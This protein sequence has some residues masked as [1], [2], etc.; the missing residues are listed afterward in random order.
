MGTILVSVDPE[1]ISEET[2]KKIQEEAPDMDVV[3][4]NQQGEIEKILDDIEIIVGLS[5]HRDLLVR[6]VNLKWF[7]QWGAGADWL[8]KHPKAAEAAFDVTSASGVHAIPISEHIVSFL[9]AF[10]RDLHHAVRSQLKGEWPENSLLKSRIFELTGKTIGIVG[11]GA[12]GKRTAEITS[13][14]GMRVLGVR[15][16]PSQDI[17][18]V[19]KIYGPDQLSDILPEVDFLVLTI[20]LTH[21]T[22]G[23]IGEHELRLMKPTA[24]IINTGRGGT[25]QQEVLVRALQEGWIAGAGL[26]VFET[27]PLPKESPLWKMD[28]VIITS[29]Y[30]GLNPEYTERVMKIF[31][32]NLRRYRS[33]EPLINRIDKKLGY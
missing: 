33:G 17:P 20:P 5:G 23:M 6:A 31:L 18:C 8:M 12:I 26:D 13:V 16:H 21:E 10:A 14:L 2:I 9:L 1:A 28:N 27:E 19:Q 3:V 15:R 4:T 30:S 32:E 22:K 11:L 24:F 7:Q 25:I 29:H